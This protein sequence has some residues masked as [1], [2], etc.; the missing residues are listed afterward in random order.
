M[1]GNVLPRCM[2]K[3]TCSDK[4]SL[5]GLLMGVQKFLVKCHKAQYI[6]KA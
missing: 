6:L 1:V 3:K 2:A 5:H 4:D